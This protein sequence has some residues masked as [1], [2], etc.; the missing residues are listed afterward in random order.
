[1]DLYAYSQIEE[2][3]A[4][5]KA[6]KIEIPRLRGIRYMWDEKTIT[7]EEMEKGLMEYVKDRAINELEITRDKYGSSTILGE[8]YPG[9]I[10][11]DIEHTDPDTKEK[12]TDH[13]KAVGIEW[14]KIPPKKLNQLSEGVKNVIVSYITQMTAYNK[15]AGRKDV[16]MIHARIG[17]DN[18]KYYGGPKL[19]KEP[20]F[21]CKADDAFD[22]TY[23]DIYAKIEVIADEDI[24]KKEG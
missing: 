2:Y 1:M 19:R 6:N 14:D 9:V 4:L 21:L 15:Y 17:G 5:L 3:E 8:K 10:Y 7:N 22:S 24:K 20:W 18:W 12:W 13:D 16:M 23:C 11:K